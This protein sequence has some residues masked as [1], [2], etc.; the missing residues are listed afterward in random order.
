MGTLITSRFLPPIKQ[1]KICKFPHQS[2]QP[3]Q[4]SMLRIPSVLQISWS[5]H[6]RLRLQ[7]I[8][9]FW[10]LLSVCPGFSQGG[11]LHEKWKAA[12][13][14]HATL[15]DTRDLNNVTLHL[16][17]NLVL[18]SAQLV[19]IYLHAWWWRLL[20]LDLRQTK[21]E[22]TF[23]ADAEQSKMMEVKRG[24]SRVEENRVEEK[25]D[26]RYGEST[27]HW[28]GG[29]RDCQASDSTLW[30]AL[31]GNKNQMREWLHRLERCKK[32]LVVQKAAILQSLIE[33]CN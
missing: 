20:A 16:R 33:T 2:S 7:F 23:K 29:T 3:S 32:S 21:K 4:P 9:W 13:S 25:L 18:F 26:P 17:I 1:D 14:K 6:Y 24:I 19:A 22:G 28:R 8:Q 31:D 27:E 5:I 12:S 10:S 11:G 15:S 30:N